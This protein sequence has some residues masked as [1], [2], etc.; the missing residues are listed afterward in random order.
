MDYY[1]RDRV[2]SRD[3]ARW[4]D[5]DMRGLV[6]AGSPWEGS[7]SFRNTSI[8]SEYG[9]HDIIGG[10]IT[11]ITDSR[12]E[13]ETYPMG[14]SRCVWD[15]GYGTC[16]APDGQGTFRYNN[17]ENRDLLSALTRVNV[18]VFL[19]HE[20]DNGVESF[21][22]WSAYQSYTNTIRHASTK[23]SAVHANGAKGE[24]R[25]DGDSQYI[26]CSLSGST[27]VRVFCYARNRSRPNQS[28]E[29]AG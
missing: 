12:G 11:G 28:S 16:G 9:Q 4:A 27:T 10:S 19:N 24:A 21:T 13:F 26:G 8:N 23:L 14:D 1:H 6:P 2:N 3:E 18:F 7:T 25:F 15:L 29:A 17:N 20:F 5:S 22:E